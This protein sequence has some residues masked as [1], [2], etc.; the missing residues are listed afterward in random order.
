A[1]HSH[2]PRYHHA[3]PALAQIG[4][5]GAAS[6][7]ERTHA[8]TAWVDRSCRRSDTQGITCASTGGEPC[9]LILLTKDIAAC[10]AVILKQQ[11]NAFSRQIRFCQGILK[12]I[13]QWLSPIWKWGT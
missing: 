8:C 3:H 5:S 13:L 10:V 7:W 4:V 11:Y 2:G 12:L 9:T 1:C 6:R